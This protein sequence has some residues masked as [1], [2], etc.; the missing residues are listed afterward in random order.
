MACTLI[1]TKEVPEVWH[2]LVT[3]LA[4]DWS[5]LVTGLAGFFLFELVAK[6]FTIEEVITISILRRF[7]IKIT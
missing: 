6:I 5:W 1:H 4:I 2:L 3:H 7:S